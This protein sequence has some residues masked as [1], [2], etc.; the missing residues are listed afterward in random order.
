MSYKQTKGLYN[1][2]IF[3]ALCSCYLAICNC[4]IKWTVAEVTIFLVKP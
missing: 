1:S 3:V 4:Y 2:L